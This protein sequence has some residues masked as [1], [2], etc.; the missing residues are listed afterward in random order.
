MISGGEE[1]TTVNLV[2]NRDNQPG[3]GTDTLYFRGVTIG[4]D[5]TLEVGNQHIYYTGRRTVNGTVKQ[6][7]VVLTTQPQLDAVIIRA[8]STLYGDLD[9][10]GSIAC[11][12]K[13]A[14]CDAYGDPL[15]YTPEADS[16]CDG[17]VV[18]DPDDLALFRANIKDPTFT[19]PHACP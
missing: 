11:K 9:G 6:N 12:E 2:D 14:F 15:E 10:D 3:S 8:Y 16:D 4:T 1:C 18:L 13:E 5:R 17:W 7:G 19:C